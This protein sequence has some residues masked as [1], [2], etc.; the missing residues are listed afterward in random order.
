MIDRGRLLAITHLKFDGRMVANDSQL[1]EYVRSLVKFTETVPERE[2]KLKLAME[3][4]DYASF[5]QCLADILD[6]L[7]KIQAKDLAE[8]CLKQIDELKKMTDEQNVDHESVVAEM[9]GFLTIMSSLSID[10]QMALYQWPAAGEQKEET[11]EKAPEAK[12]AAPPKD[13][14]PGEKIILA[15]DDAPF[16]LTTLKNCLRHAPYKL[17]CVTSGAAALRFLK[18]NEPSLFILD[19]E[20]PQ[21]NGHEL[22]RRIKENG[23][24]APIIFLT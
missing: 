5:S 11:P 23:H 2:E 9:T 12:P 1:S 8:R 15:V 10:I 13:I 18:E 16:F 24:R 21:M 7:E 22:A 20:M 19:I 14:P 6:M 3:T 17:F 4:Q